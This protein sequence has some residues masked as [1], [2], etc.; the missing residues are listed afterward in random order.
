MSLDEEVSCKTH[1]DAP[2]GFLRNASH[3]ADRYVCECEHWEE[4]KMSDPIAWLNPDPDYEQICPEIGYEATYCEQHP[5]DLGWI[6]LYAQREWVGLTDEQMLGNLLARIHRDGGHYQ[7]THGVKKA[8]EDAEAK[9]VGWL[10]M[11]HEIESTKE[12]NT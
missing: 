10:S 4:P 1:P 3:N 6:P 8:C 5:K 7:G 12:K 2:H 9:V 11:E